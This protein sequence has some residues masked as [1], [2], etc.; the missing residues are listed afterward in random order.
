[1]FF[2]MTNFC[3]KKRY[4]FEMTAKIGIVVFF[5]LCQK[6]NYKNCGLAGI[7]ISV[8]QK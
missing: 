3:P 5:K 8:L 2:S 6:E 1:M 7:D 4:V